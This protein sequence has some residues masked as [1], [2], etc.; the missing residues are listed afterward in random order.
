MPIAV[1]PASP[2][3]TVVVEPA[4]FCFSRSNAM[5]LRAEFWPEALLFGVRGLDAPQ[6]IPRG[7][8]MSV[9][10]GM[11][12]TYILFSGDRP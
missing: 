5:G 9:E 7:G 3:P 1:S 8:A 4:S 11:V 6:H 2:R 10:L 12:E